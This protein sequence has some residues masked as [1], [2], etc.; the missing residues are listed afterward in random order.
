MMHPLPLCAAA[1]A[2]DRAMKREYGPRVALN[3]PEVKPSP[4]VEPWPCWALTHAAVP[5][6]HSR[7]ARLPRCSRR[8]NSTSCRLLW[9]SEGGAPATMV[10][11]GVGGLVGTRWIP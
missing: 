2:A 5:T 3:F 6:M 1:L 11:S 4:R 9:G 7:R 10:R 8:L